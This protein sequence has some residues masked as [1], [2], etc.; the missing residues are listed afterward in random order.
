MT[1][2]CFACDVE[3]KNTEVCLNCGYCFDDDNKCPRL[4]TNSFV[5]IHTNRMCREKD[6]NMC[7]ILR[8]NN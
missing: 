1:D 3:L 4:K 5:C 2:Y 6:F 7:K 8:G